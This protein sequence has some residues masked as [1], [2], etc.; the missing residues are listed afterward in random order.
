MDSKAQDMQNWRELEGAIIVA[1]G[2]IE[3][4][5]HILRSFSVIERDNYNPLHQNTGAVDEKG[6]VVLQLVI[7][8]LDMVLAQLNKAAAGEC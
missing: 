6:D 1:A 8:T 3:G 4:V 5:R 2:H 7:F